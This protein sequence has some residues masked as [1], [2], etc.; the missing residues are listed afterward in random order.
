MVADSSG[1]KIRKMETRAEAETCA[2]VM[3]SSEPWLTLGRSRDAALSIIASPDREVY[4]AYTGD[5]PAG[6]VIIVM[7]GA[8]VGYIQSIAVFPEMRGRG[9]GSVLMGF[10]EERIFT[11]S[12]NVFIHASSFNPRARHL[13]ERLGY[14]FVGEFKDYIVPGHS[15]NLLRKT[16][17]PIKGYQPN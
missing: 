1:V 9:V 6:F 10:A 4:L 11:E 7:N 5:G 13:Y 3:A 17:G 16:K 2:G 15:E 14:E 8:L 12:P